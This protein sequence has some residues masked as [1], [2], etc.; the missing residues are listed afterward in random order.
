MPEQK[1]DLD[2]VITD[3]DDLDEGGEPNKD[4]E[5]KDNSKDYKTIA[6]GEL[7]D[8][9]VGAD[10]APPTRY[11]PPDADAD[12]KPPSIEEPT[13]SEEVEAQKKK[14]EEQENFFRNRWD[15]FIK[16][17][18]KATPATQKE[19]AQIREDIKS[20][21][22]PAEQPTD[23][24]DDDIQTIADMSPKALRNL[25]REE[26]DKA[27]AKQNMSNASYRS[28]Q[29][30]Q[31]SVFTEI[32]SLANDYGITGDEVD[33]IVE[34]VNSTHGFTPQSL[35]T[36]GESSKFGNIVGEKL[37]N[38]H[39]IKKSGKKAPASR[40]NSGVVQPGKAPTPPK[41]NKSEATQ[42][43]EKMHNLRPKSALSLL[44]R[45]K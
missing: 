15:I 43:L 22:Q 16:N 29:K 13:G 31:T 19:V 17:I 1:N 9:N 23:D 45:Y 5:Y 42:Q 20:N 41:V 2:N 37:L 38:L 39:L 25:L 12:T 36:L 24:D 6:G 14:V 33:K 28:V 30:E 3:V 40:D 7:E 35:D 4:I 18:N 32:S 21:R 11:T 26:N 34:Q 8:E 44:D 10:V 27:Q